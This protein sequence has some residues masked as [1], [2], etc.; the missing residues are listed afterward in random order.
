MSKSAPRPV[1][2]KCVVTSVKTPKITL[3]DKDIILKKSGSDWSGSDTVQ[4]TDTVLIHPKVGGIDGDDW[5]V[6]VATDCSNG[7]TP[8]KI[9]SHSGQ[10]PNN[11]HGGFEFIVVS[12]IPASPCSSNR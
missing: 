3:N 10:I 4:V 8:D 5:A 1:Q 9:F 7:A 2:F 12:P 6:T 11:S